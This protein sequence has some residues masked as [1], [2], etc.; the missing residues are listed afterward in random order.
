MT[1]NKSPHFSIR[2]L[3]SKSQL[4]RA[5]ALLTAGAIKS[6]NQTDDGYSAFYYDDTSFPHLVSISTSGEQ[7]YG[8]CDCLSASPAEPLCDHAVALYIATSPDAKELV[9]VGDTRRILPAPEESLSEAREREIT[10]RK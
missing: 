5:A 7:L 3:V 4:E 6:I 2:N 9:K 8:S 1:E 10:R